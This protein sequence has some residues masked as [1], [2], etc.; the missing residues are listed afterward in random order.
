MKLGALVATVFVFLVACSTDNT[1]NNII[2]ADEHHISIKS[3]DYILDTFT[4]EQKIPSTATAETTAKAHCAKHG[5]A[6]VYMSAV[7]QRSAEWFRFVGGYNAVTFA[8][9]GSS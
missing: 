5:K 4:F 8:C 2:S 9:L 7:R 1:D 6:S 3:R